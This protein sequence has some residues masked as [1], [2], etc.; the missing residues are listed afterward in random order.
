MELKPFLLERYFAEYEFSTRYLLSSSDC[1]GWPQ[2]K[3]L[4]MADG[5]ARKLWRNLRLGYTESRGLPLLRREISLLYKGLNEDDVLVA[6]PEEAIFIAMN[7]LLRKGDRILCTYPGYQSL[8]EIA[9]SLGCAVDLW[10]P[11]EGAQ[12]TFNVGSLKKKISP[13]TKLIIV[14]FP[15][16]PTGALPS[17]GDFHKILSLAQERGIYVFSD[18]MY[19][20][21]E[22]DLRDRLPSACELYGKAISLFGMSKTFGMAGTRIGWLATRDRAL[23]QRMAE[24]KDYTTICNSA[25]SEIL[26]LIGLRAKDE[27][28]QVHRRRIERNLTL[29]DAFFKRNRAA[30]SWIR[31]KAGTIAFP[32]LLRAKNADSFCEAVIKEA[33]VMLLPAAV[34]GIKGSH[35]RIGFGRENMPEALERL[36][37][38]LARHSAGAGLIS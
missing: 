6:A 7:C 36:E 15:H 35:F 20:F 3:I 19:R 22:V 21:L 25:P 32:K 12:W 5:E 26:A 27:I 8:Y 23:L 1:D 17:G 9:R 13:K 4:A 18:E 14:N 38:F 16:N 33:R 31:P 24:F 11:E 30:M 2:A 10:K 37:R 28:I 29:L 34:Y